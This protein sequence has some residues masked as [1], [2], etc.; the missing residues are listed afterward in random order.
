MNSVF[1]DR[2]IIM[3][4]LPGPKEKREEMLK[5]DRP[6]KLKTGSQ[7]SLNLKVKKKCKEYEHSVS[8]CQ[9]CAGKPIRG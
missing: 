1:D 4:E 3:I 9:I 5:E 8:D 7:T 2:W 6:I